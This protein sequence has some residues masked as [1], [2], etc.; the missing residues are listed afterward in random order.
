MNVRAILGLPLLAS[1]GCAVPEGTDWDE[2]DGPGLDPGVAWSCDI[3]ATSCF[4]ATT[5]TGLYTAC[6]EGYP[7][8][9]LRSADELGDTCECTQ[10]D[11]IGC[12]ERLAADLSAERIATCPP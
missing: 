11:E 5:A 3:A 9:I 6:G 4:C 1:L 7:C 8:C 10:D 12:Q 2:L